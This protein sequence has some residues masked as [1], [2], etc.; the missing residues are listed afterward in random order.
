M[1]DLKKLWY[2]KIWLFKTPYIVSLKDSNFLEKSGTW[3]EAYGVNTFLTFSL[4]MKV[5]WQE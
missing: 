3:V 1:S 2:Y 4:M 5:K